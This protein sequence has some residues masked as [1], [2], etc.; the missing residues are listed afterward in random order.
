MPVSMAYERIAPGSKNQHITSLQQHNSFFCF[1]KQPSMCAT[2]QC[3]KNLKYLSM[4]QMLICRLGNPA[5]TTKVLCDQGEYLARHA[6]TYGIRDIQFVQN[7][8]LYCYQCVNLRMMQSPV[9]YLKIC[10]HHNIVMKHQGMT[11]TTRAST[12]GSSCSCILIR[13]TNY[14]IHNKRSVT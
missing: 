10:F 7:Y 14:N 13:Q 8:F 11:C 9:S 1:R 3:D 6:L 5:W 4:L 12:L 2:H